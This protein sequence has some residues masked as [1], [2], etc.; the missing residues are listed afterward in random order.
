MSYCITCGVVIQLHQTY[1]LKY[2]VVKEGFISTF[3]GTPLDKVLPSTIS[4]RHLRLQDGR[5]VKKV[6]TLSMAN[7]K[8]FLMVL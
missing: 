7:V 1:L 6:S 8:V 3:L 4:T 5:E 2:S